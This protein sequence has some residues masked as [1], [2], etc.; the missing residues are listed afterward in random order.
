MVDREDAVS[1][2]EV[3]PVADVHAPRQRICCG[4]R[5]CH[6]RIFQPTEFIPLFFAAESPLELAQRLAVRCQLMSC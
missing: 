4:S 6:D 1:E 3:H 5:P 2:F